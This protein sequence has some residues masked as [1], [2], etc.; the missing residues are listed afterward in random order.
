MRRTV[1]L[2]IGEP[3]AVLLNNQD[4]GLDCHSGGEYLGGWDPQVLASPSYLVFNNPFAIF[5]YRLEA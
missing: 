5:C 1:S 4:L 2:I 3:D